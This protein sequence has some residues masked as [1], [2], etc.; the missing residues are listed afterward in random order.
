MRLADVMDEIAARLDTI[1][2]LRVFAYPPG[3]LTGTP[4]AIVSYPGTYTYDAT[5][6]RGSDEMRLPV[7]V[8]VGK[9]DDLR[10]R[11]LLSVYVDGGGASSVKAKLDGDDYISC[12]AVRVASVDFDVTPIGGVDQLAAVFDLDIAGRGD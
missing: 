11:D 4:A 7:V 2:G 12:S 1:E 6:G 9:P 10:T 3:S 5:Y 8:V